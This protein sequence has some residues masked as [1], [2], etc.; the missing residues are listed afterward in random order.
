MIKM[1]EK[2]VPYNKMSKKKQREIDLK[3]RKDWNGFSPVT[4]VYD[5][6]YEYKAKRRSKD[7]GEY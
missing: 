5:P 6:T 7:F 3:K 1:H 4:K 2:F